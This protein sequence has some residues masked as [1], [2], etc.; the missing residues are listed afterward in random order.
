MDLTIDF[1]TK[2][3]HYATS[4]YEEHCENFEAMMD[5]L[6]QSESLAKLAV[7]AAQMTLNFNA[8]TRWIDADYNKNVVED[9]YGMFRYSNYGSPAV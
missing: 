7:N 5:K 2:N 6:M 4:W 8:K 9:G 3:L 1:F